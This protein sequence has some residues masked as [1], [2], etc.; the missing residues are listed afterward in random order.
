MSPVRRDQDFHVHSTFSDDA[1]ST[2]AE[3]IAVA[4]TRGLRTIC[5]VDHV[6]TT[7]TW[8]PELVA[9]V[10]Q[11][12]GP[13]GLEG[14]VGVEAKILDA[15]GTLDLPAGIVGID[16]VLIADHLF[17]SAD[18]PLGPSAVRELLATGELDARDA[19]EMLLEATAL[20]MGT[21]ERPVI[22]HPFSLLPKIGLDESAVTDAMISHFALAATTSGALVEINEKWS[23]PGP[24]LAAAL[25]SAGVHLVA[26]S[27][28]HQCDA[29]GHYD[30]VAQTIAILEDGAPALAGTH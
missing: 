18:G 24:R 11:L 13:D 7:T 19:I 4:G 20:A 17:P 26:G 1:V 23:C 8:V 6:R 2:L 14:R 21:V 27:D 30:G 3:N 29:V 15:A 5:C 12:E 16:H 22:A 10:A 9:A 28:A 25:L